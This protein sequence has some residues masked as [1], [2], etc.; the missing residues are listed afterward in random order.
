MRATEGNIV[1]N[2]IFGSG[3]A[4]LNKKAMVTDAGGNVYMTGTASNGTTADF[5]TVSYDASAVDNPASCSQLFQWNCL[6]WPLANPAASMFLLGQNPL[7]SAV[8]N[9]RH[10]ANISA[11]PTPLFT[12]ASLAPG[13]YGLAVGVSYSIETL[14]AVTLPR[15]E[16]QPG[17]A[18]RVSIEEL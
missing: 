5:L 12:V 6:V 7:L 9:V 15:L 13:Q 10:A 18:F 14:N 4:V 17:A 1:P 16:S 3:D 8:W 2:T 11:Y